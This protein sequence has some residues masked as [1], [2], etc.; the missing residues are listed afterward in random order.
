MGIS[1]NISSNF[2]FM[3]LSSS[4]STFGLPMKLQEY[5]F[6]VLY[7]GAVPDAFEDD[8]DCSC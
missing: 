3:K 7:F 5:S 1:S 4:A 2:D 8:A 6:S